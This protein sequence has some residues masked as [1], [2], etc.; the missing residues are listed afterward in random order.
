MWRGPE[1]WIPDRT[2]MAEETRRALAMAGATRIRPPGSRVVQRPARR[3]ATAVAHHSTRSVGGRSKPVAPPGR[4]RWRPG[5][6][7]LR[8]GRWAGRTRDRTG[9]DRIARETETTRG[10]R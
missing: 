2:R 4:G 10:R 1:G 5:H 7:M 3:R 8:W 6:R 9:G